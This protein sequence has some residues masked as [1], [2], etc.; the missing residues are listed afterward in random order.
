MTNSSGTNV[1]F[2]NAGCNKVTA[3]KEDSHNTAPSDKQIN[4]KILQSTICSHE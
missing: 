1:I 2:E 4:E 3:V